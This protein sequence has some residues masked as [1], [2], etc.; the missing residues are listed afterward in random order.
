MKISDS[1]GCTWSINCDSMGFT[2]KNGDSLG[3][4]DEQWCFIE[5]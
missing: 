5:I 2:M 1:M 3:F 4:Y